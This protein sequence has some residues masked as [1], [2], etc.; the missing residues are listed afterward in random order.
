[1]KG[2]LYI[3]SLLLS[4]P[5]LIAGTASLLLKHTFATRN[6]LQIVTDFLFQ[7]VWGLPLAAVLFLV[8]L[9]LGIVART[10]TYATLFA[11]V[12]NI[13]ALGFVLHVFGLPH[14]FDE[15][16]FFLPLLLAL[17]GFAWVVPA[18]VSLQHVLNSRSCHD[19]C[20][21]SRK[22]PCHSSDADQE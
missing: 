7:V 20:P 8:L 4:A 22:H 16:V 15:A 13:T 6:P 12:L 11:F 10:R 19:N 3:A 9:V 2:F 18:I 21:R 17:I 14:D 5:N 1:M